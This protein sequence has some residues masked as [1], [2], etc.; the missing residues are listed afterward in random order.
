MAVTR[1]KNN[2]ITDA[3]IFANTKI[4][5]GTIVGSLFNPSVTINSN[6]AIVGN[7]TVTGNT[8]TINS[9]NTLVYDPLVIFNNGYTG[10]PS[11]DVGILVDRNLQAT[12]P[13]NYGALNSAWVWR[14]AD[15]AFEGILTTETGSTQGTIDRTAYANLIIGNTVIRTGGTNASVV[16]AVDTATGALQVKGGASFTQNVQI[17]GSASVFGANTGQI[18][19]DSNVP[20]VQVTQLTSTRYGLML[21]DTN[22][23]G[24]LALRTGTAKGAELHTFGGTNNDIYIQPDRKKS[25]WLPAGNA[26]VLI[27]NNINSTDANIAALIITGS[28][29]IAVGG[30]INVGTAASFESKRVVIQAPA[31]ATNSFSVGSGTLFTGLGSQV[32]AV[33]TGIGATSIGNNSTIVGAKAGS[34]APG[35][36]NAIFGYTAGEILSGTDSTFVGY[37]AGKSVT[38]GNYNVILGNYDGNVIAAMSN[39]VVIADGAGAPRIRIDAQGNTFVVSGDNSTTANTGAFVV[40]GGAGIGGNLNIGGALSLASNRLVLDAT[41]TGIVIGANTATTYLNTDSVIIGQKVGSGTTFGTHTTIVGAEAAATNTNANDNTLI[42]YRAGYAGPGA[43]T[44]AIGSQAGLSLTSDSQNNQLFGYNAGSL[45]TTGDYNVVLGANTMSGLT[46]VDNYI[47]LSD[48]Q[49]N[50]RIQID[51]NG[52]TTIYSTVQSGSSAD[53]ALVVYGGV[54]IGGNVHIQSNLTVSGNLTVLGTQLV[55]DV[56]N[57]TVQDAIIKLHSFANSAPLIS[58]DGLDIGVVFDYYKDGGEKYAFLGWSNQTGYLEWISNG[59]ETAGDFTGTFGVFKTGELLVS[60]AT[61]STDQTSGAVVVTGGVGV[62]GR[63]TANNAVVDNNLTASGTD[64]VVTFSPTGTGYVTVFPAGLGTIDH[65]TIGGSKPATGSFKDLI[66]DSNTTPAGRNVTF[67]GNGYVYVRPTGTVEIAPTATGDINNMYIGN[68]TPRQ[69]TFTAATVQNDLNLTSFTANSA[70]FIGATGNLAVDQRNAQFNFQRLTGNTFSTVA[71]SL[72]HA[73]QNDLLTQG[74]DTLNIRYQADSYLT[75]SDVAANTVSQSMGWTTSTSR[76]T[77][78][79]PE[80]TED[81][82]FNGV[83]GAYAYTGATP[84]YKEIAGIRYVNQGTTAAT[85][86]IGGQ[87]QLWTKRDDGA[88]TLALRVDANQISTFTGQVVVAN[89]TTSTTTTEGALYV[90]G[91]TGIGGNLNVSLGARFNDS[92]TANRDFIVRGDQ[93]A[94]LIW[95]YTNPTYNQVIVGNNLSTVDAIVGAKFH[96]NSTDAMILPKGSTAQRPG[97]ATGYGSPVAGMLRFNTVTADIEYYDGSQW[98]S[99]RTSALTVVTSQQFSGDGVETEYTLSRNATTNGTFVAINGVLQEPSLAY[100]VTDNVLTFTEAPAVND[101]INIRTVTLTAEVRGLESPNGNVSVTTENAGT[102]LKG[103]ASGQ[104]NTAA[105]LR[106][107]TTG[108][109]GTEAVTVGLS[110][111]LIHEF[112]ANTYRSGKFTIQVRNDLGASYE[113]SEVMVLHDGTTAYRTQYNRVSTLGN[114]AALGSVTVSL[115]D[116]LVKVF[117]TGNST[118]NIVTAKVDLIANAQPY[119]VF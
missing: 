95:A 37:G 109:S 101:E 26:A 55:V 1:I 32:T 57:L 35:V 17:G 69:A 98:F 58:D 74:T 118:N 68:V 31:T 27:D 76:G 4:H 85:N 111:T 59:T 67:S 99:P 50:G 13:T 48:G 60:N 106:D 116:Y 46:T 97:G 47:M 5:P 63:I 80:V 6:I 93:D 61:P 14:E 115:A 112:S 82:D 43:A 113:V 44:T 30:N 24:A 119:L 41:Q 45:I 117:Y 34:D 91:G 81:G 39:Q 2:Q 42:G 73:S 108:F 9:I 56:E 11:Y 19:I 36:N 29:G 105:F 90:H 51:N 66:V 75:Q 107:G 7:L 28:G 110:P 72:G 96:I 8:N 12:S 64:A 20:I 38:T 83:Y 16:E 86:G 65:M 88:L 3:T 10:V 102:I 52:V 54:G 89:S 103:G 40:Q 62:G 71:L 18:A 23:N 94:K 70:L 77:P 49:G 92:Q 53:G 104:S 33:G 25:I 84:E 78:T 87:A 21:T 22:N 79:A 114:G 15:G 100:N